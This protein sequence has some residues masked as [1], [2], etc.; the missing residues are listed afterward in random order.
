[1]LYL[2]V[3]CKIN[4]HIPTLILNYIILNQYICIYIYIFYILL[5]I[6]HYLFYN[7]IY[8]NNNYNRLYQNIKSNCHYN[9]EINLKCIYLEI[10]I[11]SH[12]LV[13]QNEIDS[14]FMIQIVV[15]NIV[16]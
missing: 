14:I 13:L 12:S 5:I 8:L 15:Y 9:I 3:Q 2:Y 4:I 11:F 1:M 10:I 16:Y 7:V 6:I